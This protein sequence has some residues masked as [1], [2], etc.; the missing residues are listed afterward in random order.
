MGKFRTRPLAVD[1]S[2]SPTGIWIVTNP[3]GWAF[4]VHPQVFHATYE[5]VQEPTPMALRFGPRLAYTVPTEPPPPVPDPTPDVPPAKLLV[6]IEAFIDSA[7]PIGDGLFTLNV[8]AA[9]PAY[10]LDTHKRLKSVFAVAVPS[11]AL[12][13]ETEQGFLDS[14]YPKAELEVSQELAGHR[15]VFPVHGVVAS[16]VIQYILVDED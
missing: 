3:D 6:E 2:L 14:S 5:P 8:G 13:P 4:T 10:S 11:D 7:S 1:A 15:Q 16:N 12:L 9:I